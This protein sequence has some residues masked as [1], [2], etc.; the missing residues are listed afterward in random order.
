MRHFLRFGTYTAITAITLL[1]I[2]NP[3]FR[4]ICSVMLFGYLLYASSDTIQIA[5][6]HFEENRHD[7]KRSL[8]FAI[9]KNAFDFGCFLLSI[10]IAI[11]LAVN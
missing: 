11:Y 3:Q 10:F 4:L 6:Q 7:L 2:I 8:T 9:S 1:G 5:I